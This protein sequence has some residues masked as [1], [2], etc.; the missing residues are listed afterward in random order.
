MLKI[1][2]YIAFPIYNNILYIINLQ[3]YNIYCLKIIKEKKITFNKN[4]HIQ[5]F[6]EIDRIYF[7]I[8]I[9]NYN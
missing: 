7:F 8:F 6:N 5:I 1:I 9:I 2:E 3:V 4:I